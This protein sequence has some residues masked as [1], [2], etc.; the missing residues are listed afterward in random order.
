M[1][2]RRFRRLA[3]LL[4]LAGI[5]QA[6]LYLPF[7]TPHSTDDTPSY[8]ADAHALLHGS[9]SIPLGRTDITG[10]TF[11]R[12]VWDLK[13]QDTY[14]TPGYPAF[15]AVLGGGTGDVSR[16]LVLLAQALLVGGAIF[17]CALWARRLFGARAGLLGAAAYALDPY[18]KRYGSLVLSEAPTGFLLM[19][20]VY[21]FVRA[22]QERALRWWAACGVTC[23]VLT[24]VRPIFGMTIPLVGLA[25]LARRRAPRAAVGAAAVFGACALLLV[26][27]WLARTSA[28]IGRPALQNFGVGWGLLL[29]AHGEGLNHP[30]TEVAATPG[31]IRD[32]NSVHAFAPSAAELRRSSDRYAKYLSK[33]DEHQRTLAVRLFKHRLRRDPGRVL[34]DYV[35]RAYFLW[36]IHEDWLQPGGAATA[37]LRTI[38]WI[39]LAL[40]IAGSV[41]A[42]RRGGVPALV[43]V[44]LLA[45]YTGLSALG[46][47]E[48][49]YTI[50]LRGISLPFAVLPLLA[51]YDRRRTAA[52]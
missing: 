7:V 11:P 20:A 38:D 25:S 2:D 8:T 27:P 24:L 49:R 29:A 30:A 13:Q 35:Y 16:T 12:E 9:Y 19:A 3:L 39:V 28:I 37:L 10:L 14:R 26:A 45:L 43:L 32:F 40:T 23:G 42:I 48:A 17:P 18:S 21:L 34:F 46:H 6:L 22:W 51:L 52:G 4:T 50:P 5:A 41:L 47:V 36:M 33:A 15:L 31:F 44:L 1:D